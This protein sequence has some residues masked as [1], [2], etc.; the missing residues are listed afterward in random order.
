MSETARF[1]H[2]SSD[3]P[4]RLTCEPV[5]PIR[6]VLLFLLLLIWISFFLICPPLIGRLQWRLNLL[7]TSHAFAKGIERTSA[8]PSC[9]VRTRSR[10][11]PEITVTVH[12]RCRARGLGHARDAWC[13]IIRMR[14][15]RV[16][17]VALASHTA[18]ISREHV[19]TS[20]R[21]SQPFRFRLHSIAASLRIL[22]GP[23]LDR[24]RLLIMF[25]SPH[26]HD[27]N[28]SPT[29]SW[30]DFTRACEKKTFPSL[31]TLTLGGSGSNPSVPQSR[32]HACPSISLPLVS[33]QVLLHCLVAGLPGIARSPRVA[34][35]SESV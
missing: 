1:F 29:I 21:C 23:T 31:W 10:Q 14:H 6:L 5:L 20:T 35:S 3:Y 13:V 24:H 33:H 17:R 9:D 22:R 11:N 15:D 2:E 32:G 4:S 12:A 30:L 34:P 27:I 19:E 26:S 16:S 7:I 18:S 8:C 28:T 25:Y